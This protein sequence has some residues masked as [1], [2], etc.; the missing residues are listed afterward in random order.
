MRLITCQVTTLCAKSTM[1]R[2]PRQQRDPDFFSLYLDYTSQTECPTFFHRWTSITS[3]AAWIGRDISFPFGHFNVHPNLYVMFVGLAGTKKSTAIKIGAKLLAEAGYNKFAARKTRQE[4]FLLDMADAGGAGEGVDSDILDQNLFGPGSGDSLDLSIPAEV[5]VPADEINNFIGVGNLDFMSILGELWDFE[6][7]YDYKL[8]NSKDIYIPDPTVN[9]LGGN[10]FVGL[11]R[12]FPPEAVEQGFFS[13]MLFIYAEPT[14]VKYTIPAE[15]DREIQ[16]QLIE[17]LKVIKKVVRGKVTISPTA[18]R[19]LDKIYK[20]WEGIGDARFDAYEN[21]RII[22]L[23]K[24]CMVVMAARY[25]TQ[26]EEEDLIYAN[27]ILTFTEHLMPKALGEFGMARNSE[28]THKIMQLLETSAAAG[29]PMTFQQLWK[30]TH[31]DLER[32]EQLSEILFNL[33]VADKV[34]V[35]VGTNDYLPV[36]EIRKEPVAGAVDWSLLTE[37]ERIL[38]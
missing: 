9:I 16:A 22:H 38:L 15:P 14:G 5:F 2:D 34:Q 18:Y 35:V 11:N 36:K 24:I 31:V 30:G 7:V 12:L 3:L 10:T 6:G 25:A 13:R 21:R 26:I 20:D 28:V 8:K 27:T 1:P 19:L 4:K 33:Q 17:I 37:K 32:R 23:L 29:R